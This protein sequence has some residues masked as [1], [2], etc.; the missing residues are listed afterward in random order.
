MRAWVTQQLMTPANAARFCADLESICTMKEGVVGHG[1]KS[2]V[3]PDIRVSEVS[4]P[5]IRHELVRERFA[6][7]Q[8]DILKINDDSFGYELSTFEFQF[9]SYARGAD[10]YDQH[11][12]CF[13]GD[14]PGRKMRK[15]SGSLLLT[16]P[17]LTRGGTFGFAR[18]IPAIRALRHG[19]AVVFA[20][21]CPHSVS[22]IMKG[23]R[24][25][26]VWW[27]SGPSYR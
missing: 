2:R 23:V 8:K 7:L 22:P 11:C 27:V 17:D 4:F 15:L 5:P 26:L 20:S 3:D 21:F 25:S 18:G 10:R 6:D 19:E 24:K 1:G 16:D 9:T 13:F 12:D 14:G